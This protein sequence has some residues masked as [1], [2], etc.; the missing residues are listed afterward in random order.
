M[1]IS[2]SSITTYQGMTL[3]Q[4]NTRGYYPYCG[5]QQTPNQTNTLQLPD[6]SE[7]EKTKLISLLTEYCTVYCEALSE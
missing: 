2:P 3:E 6:L 4:S 1:I 5:R 7:A